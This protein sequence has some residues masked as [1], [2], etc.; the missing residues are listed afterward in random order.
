MFKKKKFTDLFKLISE[1]TLAQPIIMVD[2]VYTQRNF[3]Q[4][5]K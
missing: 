1:I 2:S 4:S 3:L 5:K